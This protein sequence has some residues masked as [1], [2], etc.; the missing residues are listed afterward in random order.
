MIFVLLNDEEEGA[1][2]DALWWPLTLSDRWNV[3]KQRI[4]IYIPRGSDSHRRIFVSAAEFCSNGA[5]RPK[6][7][8]NAVEK[9]DIVET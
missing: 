8:G 2:T 7:D 3:L 6:R 5:C 4:Y 9:D 1:E